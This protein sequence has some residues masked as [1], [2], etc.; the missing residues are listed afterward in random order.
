MALERQSIEKKDFPIARRGY[1]PE[2]VDAHLRMVADQ[3]DEL[4]RSEGQ[5]AETLASTTAEQVR[6]ILE[7]AESSAAGI[8]RRA[9]E[10]A[11]ELTAEARTEAQSVQDDAT[12]R[13][14]EYV[15]RVSEAA[16]RMLQRVEAMESQ[17][18]TLV[19]S[20]RTGSGRLVSDLGS[21]ESDLREVREIVMPPSPVTPPML[22]PASP[23]EPVGPVAAASVPEA[24]VQSEQ[25]VEQPVPPPAEVE[26]A[27]VA[28]PPA[29]DGDEDVEGARL[30]ALN[31]ALNG[32][33]REETDQYLAANFD[34][35][36]RAAL[37]DEVYANVGG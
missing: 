4:T 29:A 2:A 24:A 3:L 36:D 6:A 9:E 33:P 13:A 14:R 12:T 35:S 25:H 18:G 21:L 22:E 30:V 1:D 10:D 20:L 34:L 7:A 8:R 17:L 16:T 23:R 5:P 32:T 26:A 19:E 15:E 37:L 31:M 28:G 11:R 27:A